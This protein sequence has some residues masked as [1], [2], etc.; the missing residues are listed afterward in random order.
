MPTISFQISDQEKEFIEQMVKF[1]G[2]SLSKLI[3]KKVLESLEEQIDIE[4]YEQMIKYHQIK[5]ESIS[6]KEMK[7]ELGL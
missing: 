7:R 4:S 5:D 6:H 1:N 3:R 2:M